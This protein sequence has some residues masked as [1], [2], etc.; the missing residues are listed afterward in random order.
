MPASATLFPNIHIF[1]HFFFFSFSLEMCD[2]F[3]CHETNSRAM[4]HNLLTW[5]QVILEGAVMFLPI[6]SSLSSGN[7]SWETPVPDSTRSSPPSSDPHLEPSGTPR[8]PGCPRAAEGCGQCEVSETLQPPHTLWSSLSRASA[9]PTFPQTCTSLG[10]RISG[11]NLACCW[12]QEVQPLEVL[13]A[14][15]HPSTLHSTCFPGLP[16]PPPP[17]SSL[18]PGSC[19]FGGLS[20]SL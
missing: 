5:L 19:P 15:C 3:Y 10:P 20:L 16:G 7:L 1:L 6:L 2:L 9:L 14:S 13:S 12:A 11:E 17:P 8:K 18:G 4:F